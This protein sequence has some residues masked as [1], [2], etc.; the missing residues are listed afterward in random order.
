MSAILHVTEHPTPSELARIERYDTATEPPLSLSQ[1]RRTEAEQIAWEAAEIAAGW[2]P[3]APLP[4][5]VSKDTI[6]TRL[7][8]A[9]ALSAAMAAFAAQS[10]EDQF[11]WENGA[12]FWNTNPKLLALCA[13]LSLDPAIILAADPYL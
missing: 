5:R 2:V 12:W 3:G 9:A 4:Y 11:L 6:L 13:A 7:I 10:A 8:T 1:V